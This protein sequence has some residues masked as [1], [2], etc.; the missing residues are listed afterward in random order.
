MGVASCYRFLSQTTW[1]NEK[2]RRPWSDFFSSSLIWS[3][4]FAYT[5]LSENLVYKTSRQLLL[6]PNL[7]YGIILQKMAQQSR[8]EIKYQ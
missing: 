2:Q 3:A 8:A 4:L 5:I 1:Q 7:L 6:F